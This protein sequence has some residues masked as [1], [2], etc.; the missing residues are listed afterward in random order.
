[1]GCS[2]QGVPRQLS[3]TIDESVGEDDEEEVIIVME[4]DDDERDLSL[5]SEILRRRLRRRL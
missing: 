3:S 2:A 4:G 5:F 1:M